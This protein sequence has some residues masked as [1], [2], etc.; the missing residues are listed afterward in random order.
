MSLTPHDL[1]IKEHDAS[2]MS[3]HLIWLKYSESE[4]N[5]LSNASDG[6]AVVVGK[7]TR[8]AKST[9]P[10]LTG[11]YRAVNAE[12]FASDRIIEVPWSSTTPADI[13]YL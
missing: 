2:S 1:N 13:A 11:L 4:G 12:D 6:H 7:S 5:A 9:Q 8:G 3:F 10:D